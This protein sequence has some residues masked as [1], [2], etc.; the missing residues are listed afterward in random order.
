MHQKAKDLSCVTQH[1]GESNPPTA[2]VLNDKHVAIGQ[3]FPRFEI[4]K[5]LGQGTKLPKSMDLQ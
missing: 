4:M 3:I 1:R 2:G 5:L